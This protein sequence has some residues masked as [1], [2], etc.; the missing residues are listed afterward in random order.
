MIFWLKNRKPN[1]WRDRREL[2]LDGTVGL[3]QISE[4]IDI[5]ALEE[6]EDD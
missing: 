3:V 6:S 2:E 1:E 5:S 4:N